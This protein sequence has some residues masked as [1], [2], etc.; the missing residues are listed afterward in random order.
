MRIRKFKYRHTKKAHWEGGK[1]DQKRK[2]EKRE[3]VR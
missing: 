1:M 3:I 2:R